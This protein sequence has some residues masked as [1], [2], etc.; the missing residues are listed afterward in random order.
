MFNFNKLSRSNKSNSY[1]DIAYQILAQPMDAL[2]NELNKI[3]ELKVSPED[4]LFK[5]EH[6]AQTGGSNINDLLKRTLDAQQFWIPS[7]SQVWAD[8]RT[9]KLYE[10][11]HSLKV[12]SAH[13]LNGVQIKSNKQIKSFTFLRDPRK[14]IMSSM[15][16]GAITDLGVSE[17]WRLSEKKLKKIKKDIGHLNFQLYEL[18]FKNYERK[19]PFDQSGTSPLINPKNLQGIKP[20]DLCRL[21]DERLETDLVFIG[22]TENFSES[23]LLL[24]EI[25][26]NSSLKLWRPGLFAYRKYTFEEAPQDIQER[27]EDLCKDEMEFYMK[28]KNVLTN[29]VNESSNLKVLQAYIEQNKRPDLKFIQSIQE[30]LELAYANND[31]SGHRLRGD[32]DSVRSIIIELEKILKLYN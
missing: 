28:C 2:F 29:L 26:G 11:S 17:F 7:Y 18:A 31:Q 5:F 6:I 14:M 9:P 22:I 13:Y 21:V 10:S 20:A 16:T 3:F 25:L 24:F 1:S 15:Q 30:K 27:I 19:F 12:L 32:L 23:A 8:L 4:Y